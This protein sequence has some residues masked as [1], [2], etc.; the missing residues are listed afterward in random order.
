MIT[1]AILHFANLH[2]TI[3]QNQTRTIVDVHE[4][5]FVSN[6]TAAFAVVFNACR[7]NLRMFFH[8]CCRFLELFIIR[9]L[10][11]ALPCF[12]DT[13]NIFSLFY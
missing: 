1:R 3:Y 8:S 7:M 13:V 10:Y 2:P 12:H 5:K 11:F 9:P 6:T 4:I